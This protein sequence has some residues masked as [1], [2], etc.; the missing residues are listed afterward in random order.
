VLVP[1]LRNIVG[2]AI[3]I[4]DSADTTAAAM[5]RLL[6]QHLPPQRTQ[7]LRRV[8]LLA[9]DAPERFARVGARFLGEPISAADVELVDV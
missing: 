5:R 3:N 8:S 9:T 6:P 1:A 2:S 4:V 7:G